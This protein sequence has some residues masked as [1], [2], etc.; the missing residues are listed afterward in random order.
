[1]SQPSSGFLF[2]CL[3]L[4]HIFNLPTMVLHKCLPLD[5][6]ED[7]NTHTHTITST[8][9]ALLAGTVWTLVSNGISILRKA[10]ENN[11][12]NGCL[13]VES[14][15]PT[16]KHSSKRSLLWPPHLPPSTPRAAL[17]QRRG[18][19]A[20]LELERH[21]KRP[22]RSPICHSSSAV[23]NEKRLFAAPRRRT[24]FLSRLKEMVLNSFVRETSS[25]WGLHEKTG[26][27]DFIKESVFYLSLWQVSCCYGYVKASSGSLQEGWPA[28][29]ERAVFCLFVCFGFAPV[30][31]LQDNM[32]LYDTMFY[33]LYT[34]MNENL[35]F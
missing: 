32:P 22:E 19:H 4:C 8:L 21:S 17:A 10:F 24:D 18:A 16:A 13:P 9:C 31:C 15:N 23:Q 3:H 5:E 29:Q 12:S 14:P 2:V 7:A 11:Y 28:V 35:H 6:Q 27:N 25:V 26:K 1:M 20:A 30:I 33:K 34:G